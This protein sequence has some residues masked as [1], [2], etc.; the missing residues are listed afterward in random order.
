MIGCL[1]SNTIHFKIQAIDITTLVR[2]A[3]IEV[4][5]VIDEQ[6]FTEG[7]L[8]IL[9]SIGPKMQPDKMKGIGGVVD[10]GYFFKTVKGMVFIVQG[11]IYCKVDLLLPVLSAGGKGNCKAQYKAEN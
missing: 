5:S 3:E 8:I 9:V 1:C 4:C 2:F 10:I 7:R 11:N 6:L